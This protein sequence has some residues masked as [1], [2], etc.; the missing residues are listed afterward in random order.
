LVKSDA[1]AADEGNSR[2]Q[3]SRVQRE[4]VPPIGLGILELVEL[5]KNEAAVMEGPGV[6]RFEPY[7]L[8][9]RRKRLGWAV[10]GFERIGKVQVG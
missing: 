8:V 3:K 9:D 1:G 7:G 2:I 4:R 10:Q 5:V 6:F